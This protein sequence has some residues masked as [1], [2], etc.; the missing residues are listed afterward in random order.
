MFK[1][2]FKS[3]SFFLLLGDFCIRSLKCV[4]DTS[5]LIKEQQ[6]RLV[7]LYLLLRPGTAAS[8]LFAEDV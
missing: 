6:P 4:K 7:G 3:K 2:I 5:A 1:C 8:S